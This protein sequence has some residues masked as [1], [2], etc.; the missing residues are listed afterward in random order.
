VEESVSINAVTDA[1]RTVYPQ[2]ETL[3]IAQHIQPRHL[4]VS[5]ETALNR[6]LGLPRAPLTTHL[7]NFAARLALAPA[8]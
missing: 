1:V 7:Q 8:G 2:A 6:R 5:P 4:R 3:Y